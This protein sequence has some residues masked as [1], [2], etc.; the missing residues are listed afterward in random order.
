[1]D[2]VLSLKKE[3]AEEAGYLFSMNV[4]E[5]D[6]I[7]SLATVASFEKDKI[8]MKEGQTNQSLY[9]IINGICAVERLRED[10]TGRVELGRMRKGEIF[11]ELTFLLGGTA[12]VS[13][14]AQSSHVDI[15]IINKLDLQPFFQKR[16]DLCPKFYKY[17]ATQISN[18]IRSKEAQDE[19]LELLETNAN[20]SLTRTR[21]GTFQLTSDVT[22][23]SEDL[24]NILPSKGRDR[25]STI[26]EM[27]DQRRKPPSIPELKST[28]PSSSDFTL[29][30]TSLGII[31][32]SSPSNSKSK[33]EQRRTVSYRTM[34]AP[35]KL[36]VPPFPTAT[37]N[38]SNKNSSN[39]NNSNKT[40]S[41][42]NNSNKNSSN[43]N[44]FSNST[45]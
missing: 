7:I 26:S 39:N 1:M 9:Q 10:G 3:N 20:T 16:M 34:K 40:S 33:L 29:L 21:T 42:N 8:I 37:N 31:H 17:L 30:D 32:P 4:T 22:S 15:L 43:N 14:V 35:P 18:R 2:S 5:W 41:N 45:K 44:N 27:P 38:N 6:E 12:S 11:G 23:N 36:E 25:S 24:F 28:L 19:E 13:V